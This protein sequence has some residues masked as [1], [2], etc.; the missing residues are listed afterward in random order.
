MKRENRSVSSRGFSLVELMF[1]MLIFA[2]ILA[3]STPSI[4][5]WSTSLDY[6]STARSIASALRQARSKAITMNRQHRVEFD[7]SDLHRYRLTAGDRSASSNT[8]TSLQNWTELPR[9]VQLT[10]TSLSSDATASPPCKTVEFNPNGMADQTTTSSI[11]VKD[12]TGKV[13]LTVQIT[14]VG[15]ITVR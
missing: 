9:S 2:I 13:H 12:N 15:Q 1:T 8:W 7:A 6:R 11:Q 4:I 14:N 10:E 5:E 3:F